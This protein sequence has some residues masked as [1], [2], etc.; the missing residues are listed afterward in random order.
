[1]VYYPEYEQ[2]PPEFYQP[3]EQPLDPWQGGD[4]D[5]R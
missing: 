3:V 2:A 1:M 4:G 5:A